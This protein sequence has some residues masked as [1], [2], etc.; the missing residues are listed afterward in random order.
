MD[1]KD[2]GSLFVIDSPEDLLI[3]KDD[4]NRYNSFT[5][6]FGIYDNNTS[7][8]S[9][10]LL[11]F[12]EKYLSY[13]CLAK[14]GRMVS[15]IKRKFEFYELIKLDNYPIEYLENTSTKEEAILNNRIKSKS[16]VI[17]TKLLKKIINSILKH[18][19]NLTSEVE[20][21][22]SLREL[23]EYK[24][25]GANAEILLQE[26]DALGSVLDIFSGSNK[27]REDILRSWAPH[28]EDL[29]E[30]DDENKSA[31]LKEKSKH[32]SSF[33]SGI[34]ERLFSEESTLQHDLFNYPEMQEHFHSAG[35]SL[36]S[37]GERRLEVIYANRNALE[38]TLG[39][40][41]IYHNEI[42]NS[43]I[44]VQYKIM[45]QEN[46]YVYRPD[47]NIAD[48][49]HRMNSFLDETSKYYIE[50]DTCY[51]LKSDNEFRLNNNG[52]FI[53]LVPNRGLTPSS[54]ELIKGMYI[55]NE[56]MN[57]LLS[58]HG[59]KGR[60]GGQI[61]TFANAPRY[62]TNTDFTHLINNGWIGT[63]GIATKKV[64]DIVLEYIT[65]GHSMIYARETKIKSDSSD[66]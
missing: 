11:F 57:F 8:L 45:K 53:K 2:D 35:I 36:F 62:L 42:Y 5:D 37:Q 49:L 26:R 4:N 25:R 58:P 13:L 52:F 33:F 39:V 16:G 21:I 44:L 51:I 24:I 32:H 63:N 18:K 40:D 12:S 29:L 3:N 46:E 61:I 15:T 7:K 38:K 66:Y 27:L 41:L 17:P 50:N 20:R 56:Y 28:R 64:R 19:P 34:P 48:E 6:T 1:I 14:S 22:L 60:R 10:S 30:V 43:F 23:S 9:V 65:K 59:P 55:H 47:S 54:G 31:V